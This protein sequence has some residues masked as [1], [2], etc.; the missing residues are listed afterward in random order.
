MSQI[1]RNLEAAGIVL[2]EA[3]APVAAY[4]GYVLQGDFV[5]VSGQLPFVDGKLM[6]TGLLGRDVDEATAAAAAR[7]CAINLLAQMKAACGGDLERITRC[8]KL[9]GFV[10]STPDFTAH[11]AV[12][13]GAS[14]LMA[15]ILGERG[16]HARAAVGVAALP[17]N[18]CV[19]V[20]GIFAI[21]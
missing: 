2:P 10:A 3:P 6:A 8:I 16:Q 7:Q 14:Q 1:E 4:V 19:E 13:N 18:A 12:V 5:F 9:G 11:P 20:E 17:L 15:E 21:R